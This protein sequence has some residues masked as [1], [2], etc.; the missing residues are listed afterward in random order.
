MMLALWGA[1]G[2]CRTTQ[3]DRGEAPP[4]P[5]AAFAAD[6]GDFR[7]AVEAAWSARMRSDWAA[8]FAFLDPDV[9]RDA[10][11]EEYAAWAEQREPFV[12][13]SFLIDSVEVSDGLG[14]AFVTSRTTLRRLPA[15]P[16]VSQRVEK[17]RC[18]DGCW[19]L[20]PPEL[21][22]TLPAPPSQRDRAAEPRLAERFLAAWNARRVRSADALRGFLDP[23][24]DAA[25]AA[26][27]IAMQDRRL[28]H[29]RC[30][31][32]W[33]EA[34]GQRGRVRARLVVQAADPAINEGKPATTEMTERWIRRGDEWYC[35]IVNRDES[36]RR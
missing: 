1:A 31:V 18:R 27:L 13:H 29:L 26:E 22:G 30:D 20:V 21:L 12:V 16:V 24:D 4:T 23:E 10:T 14:W 7:L 32:L 25:A 5:P 8:L 35:D 9:R 17:W 36:A 15:E 6:C 19:A 28:E 33:T 2:G 11:A 34:I 3:A